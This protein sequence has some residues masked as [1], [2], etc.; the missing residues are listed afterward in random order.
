METMFMY[1]I[2]PLYSVAFNAK[3]ASSTLSRAI[4]ATFY[5]EQESLIQNAVY[6][7]GKGP[8]NTQI[9]WLCPREEKPSKPIVLVIRNPI[10]RFQSAMTQAGLS[11]INVVL[12]ALEQDKEIKFQK[13]YRKIRT[14]VHFKHQFTFAQPSAKVFKLEDLNSAATYIGLTLPLPTINESSEEKPVLTPEQEA[15]IIA[16][17]SEDQS[18]YEAIPVGGMN[19]TYTPP[20]PEPAVLHVPKSVTATQIRLWLV[21]NGI[22]MTQIT[23]AISSIADTQTRS[24]AEVLWE[25]APYIDRTNPLV[26]TIASMLNM[27][28]Y[29][30]DQAFIEAGNIN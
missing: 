21:R 20:S 7:T 13:I 12:D 16:Y 1:F 6:P 10:S 26:A 11:D 5:P 4:I 8:D 14:D 28:N 2:T 23:N 19:Y 9:H 17:Y 24:E 15:R 25:Y 22:T 30:I 27:D 3:V 29:A 18:L